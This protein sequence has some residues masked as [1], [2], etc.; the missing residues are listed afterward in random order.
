MK[1]GF[2]LIEMIVTIGL[3]GLLGTMMAVGMSSVIKNNNKKNCEKMIG[4]IEAAYLACEADS[5]C[6]NPNITVQPLKDY[7]LLADDKLDNPVNNESMAGC[8]FKNGV[9]STEK[10]CKCE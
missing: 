8:T 2:T 5:K 4:R 3:L 6:I 10:K 7:G 9:L 1:K